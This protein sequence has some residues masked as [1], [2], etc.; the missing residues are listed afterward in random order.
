MS[1][2]LR[3][4]TLAGHKPAFWGSSLE[5]KAGTSRPQSQSNGDEPSPPLKHS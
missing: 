3:L 5:G 4:R 1:N 2:Q